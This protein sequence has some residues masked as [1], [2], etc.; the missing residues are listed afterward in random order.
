MRSLSDLRR[1]SAM[2]EVFDM[3]VWQL[4]YSIDKSSWTLLELCCS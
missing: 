1:T 4:S 3:G 2:R